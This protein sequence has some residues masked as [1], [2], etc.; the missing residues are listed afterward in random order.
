M[1]AYSFYSQAYKMLETLTPVPA[2]CGKLCEKACCSDT[3][4]ED[5]SEAGMYLYPGEEIMFKNTSGFKILNSDF[6]YGDKNAKLIVCTKECNRAFR[7][8][9]CRVFPLICYK[10]EASPMTIII[11]PRARR[12]CPLANSFKITD[13]DLKFTQT[14]SYI[15]KTMIKEKHARSFITEQSYLLDE[16]LNFLK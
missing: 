16:Y 10:K 5:G 3:L 11:D 14:V 2:D 7:P 6:K 9:S 1:N 8:L 12:M 4:G 13:F 15:F